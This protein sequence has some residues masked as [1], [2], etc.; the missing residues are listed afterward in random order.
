MVDRGEYI[1]DYISG[2]KIKATKEEI[3]A[4]QVFSKRLV[5]E[6][7]YDKNQ[8][9]TRPQ[10]KIKSS[11]SG[12]PKYPVDI[13]VFN[14]SRKDYDN[15]FMIVECKK[16][17]KS[18]GK[19]QLKIYCSLSPIQIGVW[20]N[21]K[22]HLY[23]RK[24][25]KSNGTLEYLELPSI[26]MAGQDVESIGTHKR[27]DLQKPTDLMATFKDIRYH[28]AG[29]AKGITRDEV[30]AQQLINLLFCKIYDEINKAPSE[31]VEFRVE[32]NEKPKQVKKRIVALFNKK[33]KGIE[34]SDVF[35]KNDQITLDAD[36]IYYVV[37]ELQ[38]Y[39][40]TEADRDTIGDAFEVFIGNAL[41]GA[42]GQFFT[43][44]NIVRTAVNIIDPEPYKYIIDPACG[45]GGFI[46]V[47]LEHVWKKLEQE[48]KN[49]KWSPNILEKKKI[50]VATK[51]FRGIDKDSFLAKVSKAYM[52]LIGDGRGGVFCENSLDF[53]S[54][55]D[56]YAKKEI[57]L[58]SFDCVFTNPPFGRK[59]RIP[60]K[61]YPQYDLG[62]EWE[63]N[64]KTGK[65]EKIPQT[66]K[67]NRPPQILFL[68]RCLQLLKPGGKMAIVLPDG[69]LSNP[70]DQY[71][72][73]SVHEK[74]KIIGLID[75]PMS[76]FLPNTPTKIHLVILEKNKPKKDDKIFMAFA[77]TCGHDKR[78]RRVFK[79]DKYGKQVIDDD[80]LEIG[81]KYQENVNKHRKGYDR[82]GFFVK[83]SKLKP[84]IFM[85]KYYNPD[86][87]KYLKELKRS[88]KYDIVSIGELNDKGIIS[89]KRGN[90]IG[91]ENYGTGDIPFIRTSEICNWEI[92]ADPTHCISEEIYKKYKKYQ[93]LQ[94]DDILI[95]NDGT[96]LMGRTAIL[97]ENDL[98]IIIQ[99]HIRRIRVLEPNTISPYLLLF[100]LGLNTVQKQ[101]ESKTFRQA[102]ISTLGNRLLEVKIPIPKDKKY[103]NK[104][105]NVVK[106]IVNERNKLRQKAN[107][108]K[109]ESNVE[110]V[111]GI[112]NKAKLGNL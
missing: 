105:S 2:K 42:E 107:S 71:V 80:I 111:M 52:A 96:Y 69:I 57:K 74:A 25:V 23:L 90:E 20:F 10:F 50:E 9:Q 89:I 93:D 7:K 54:K 6:F 37:G 51:Y 4:V 64:K 39:C 14:D 34:Y 78:G 31:Q 62:K 41:K 1:V 29:S 55:W 92:I 82:L 30:L 83:Y 49:K 21:G 40:L 24:I 44:R 47:A 58:G 48:G 108:M 56:A 38:D 61:M 68:E 3:D 81:E 97:S 5:D 79:Y 103:K 12:K 100:L 87:P 77:K 70:K 101:I 109:F 60:K 84:N 59:I 88:N 8:I 45:S 53:P 22:E 16:K 46:I 35:D 99:S 94:K 76:S 18:I 91:S 75:C 32:V 19:N 33:V 66:T 104:I 110:N 106:S 86:I 85:P 15:L 13:A 112:K 27:K 95:V 98:K 72:F 28:L 65:W 36:S 67:S 26:P 63:K 102:T 73:K 43:P 17:K 11:P